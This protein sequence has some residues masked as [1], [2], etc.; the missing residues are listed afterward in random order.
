MLGI[1]E[2]MLDNLKGD[3]TKLGSITDTVFI[4]M[5]DSM[6]GSMRP[7]VQLLNRIV[8]GFNSFRSSITQ[9]Q[10]Q[11]VVE[12]FCLDSYKQS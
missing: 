9:G 12:G 4:N 2:Q 8:T 6:E 3:F 11:T 5:G 10:S 1:S 7:V